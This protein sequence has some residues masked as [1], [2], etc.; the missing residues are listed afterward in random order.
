MVFHFN[1]WKKARLSTDNDINNDGV[2]LKRIARDTNK[3]QQAWSMLD[4]S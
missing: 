3:Q 4:W 1:H 2:K